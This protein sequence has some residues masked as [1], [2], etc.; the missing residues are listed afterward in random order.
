MS[1]CHGINGVVHA[2]GESFAITPNM[3]ADGVV[4]GESNGKEEH[5]QSVKAGESSGSRRHS[6]KSMSARRHMYSMASTPAEQEEKVTHEHIVYR[7]QDYQP[8]HTACGVGE[9]QLH[10]H[11]HVQQRV[12]QMAAAGDSA[13]AAA[14]SPNAATASAA[15]L[16]SASPSRKLGASRAAAAANTPFTLNGTAYA[17]KR[18]LELL[19]VNDYDRLQTHGENTEHDTLALG[20]FT[21]E[22]E[23]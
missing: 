9:E 13:S 22:S 5:M 19:I 21:E 16:S 4:N 11:E 1:T 10:K 15:K 7:L 20:Q 3:L 8:T 17:G 14:A 6:A 2:H 18:F 12:T 23:R